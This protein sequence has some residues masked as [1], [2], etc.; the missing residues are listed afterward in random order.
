[1][2]LEKLRSKQGADKLDLIATA[3]L[4]LFVTGAVLL[5]VVLCAD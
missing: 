4:V 5:V 2:N 3:A 1:M